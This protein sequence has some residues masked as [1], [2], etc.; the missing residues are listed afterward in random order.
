MAPNVYEDLYSNEEPPRDESVP[1]NEQAST[2]GKL[3]MEIPATEFNNMM[4]VDNVNKSQQKSLSQMPVRDEDITIGGAEILSRGA[5]D[6]IFRTYK[7][8]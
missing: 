4:S 1:G 8:I 7:P 5:S 6:I 3:Q 2:P